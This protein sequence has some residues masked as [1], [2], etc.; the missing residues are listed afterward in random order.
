MTHLQFAIQV[1]VHDSKISRDLLTANHS[2]GFKVETRT[3]NI[4]SWSKNRKLVTMIKPTDKKRKPEKRSE[5]GIKKNDASPNKKLKHKQIA[6]GASAKSN[7]KPSAT[8][9]RQRRHAEVVEEAKLLWNQLRQKK[10]SPTENRELMDKLMPLITGKVQEIALQHDASRVVQAAIQFGNPAE[11]KLILKELCHDV[12]NIAELSKLQYAHFVVLKVIKYCTDEESIRM[13][14]KSLKG[15]MSKLAVHAVASRVVESL[16]VTMAPKDLA[17]LKQEL[18]GP[19]FSLFAQDILSQQDIK[20]PSLATNLA[21]APDKKAQALDFVQRLIS[22]GLEKSLYGLTFFQ[23]LLAEYIAEASPKEIRLMASTAADNAIHLLST[24]AGSR[25]VA[26]FVAYGTAKDR[27]RIMKSLKGYSRSGLLHHDAYIAILRIVQL[28]DDTVSV[29]KNI[30]NELLTEPS[31]A[32]IDPSANSKHVESRHP[33]LELAVSDTAS[34][35]FQM[36]LEKDEKA[37]NKFFDPYEQ[38]VLF[39]NPMVQEDNGKGKQIDVPTS[40]KDEEVRR[41]ELIKHLSEP[42]IELCT[43]CPDEL[44]RSRPG[45]LI[46]KGIYAA[47]HP[48]SVV[49]AALDACESSVADAPRGSLLE[50]RDGHLAIKNLILVDVAAKTTERNQSTCDEGCFSAQFLARFKGKLVN[51]VAKSNR[52]AF[53]VAALCKVPTIR[54]EVINELSR[55]A[56]LLEKRSTGEGAT[57]GF[58]A[59]LSEIRN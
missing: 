14:V 16:F 3:S 15:H 2:A 24:R 35:L 57:A 59:L 5:S 31:P 23:E 54:D 51:I 8:Q 48:V 11:R 7:S 39:P 46:L 56:K 42:L 38:S 58:K 55:D 32:K 30:L 1:V 25:A 33:L 45:A 47:F 53:V 19:H 13:V 43:K 28:T 22:K 50:D 21:M 20:I 34:K 52:G 37:R 40:L 27:K 17:L 44:L 9:Q 49:A 6:S 26:S 12:N 41:K 4:Y 36:L 29:Q 18:Y 10:N